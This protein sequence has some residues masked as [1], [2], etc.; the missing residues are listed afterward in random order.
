M[1]PPLLIDVVS[2]VNLYFFLIVLFYLSSAVLLAALA[3]C[4]G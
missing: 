1:I 4:V 2:V 3:L